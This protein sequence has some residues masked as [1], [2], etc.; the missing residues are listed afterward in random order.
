M[1]GRLLPASETED[2][3]LAW[4]RWLLPKQAP[5][6]TWGEG[7]ATLEGHVIGKPGMTGLAL[8]P[9]LGAGY[10]HLSKD[11]YDGFCVG[12][13][14]RKAIQWLMAD[15]RPDGTFRSSLGT[16]DHILATHGLVEAYGLTGSNLFK[17]QAQ[18]GIDALVALQGEGAFGEDRALHAWGAMALK[19]A[20]I[21]GLSFHRYGYDRIRAFYDRRANVPADSGEMAARIF[22]DKNKGDPRLGPGA[23]LLVRRTPDWDQQDFAYWHWGS[24]ALFQYDGPSGPLWKAWN[25]PLKQTLVPTQ[26]PRGCWPGK[27]PGQTLVQTTL[28]ALTLEVYYRYANVFG[29]R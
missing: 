29:T 4:L 15:Q 1:I 24:L 10:S 12:D 2:A 28:A 26:H 6:G 16:M 3:V 25:E 22:M 9:M 11:V 8:L 17:D 18:K 5:E 20:E 14:V 13:S 19:S 27:D 23:D 7:R 21:S